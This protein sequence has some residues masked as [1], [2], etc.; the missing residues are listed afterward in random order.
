MKCLNCNNKKDF[1]LLGN[2]N[3]SV[4]FINGQLKETKKEDFNISDIYPVICKKCGSENID[5]KYLE[6]EKILSKVK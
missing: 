4:E 2:Q 1:I 3:F 6:I 5:F